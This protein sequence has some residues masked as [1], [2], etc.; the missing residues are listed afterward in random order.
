MKY[1]KY[2]KQILVGNSNIWLLSN[3]TE[4]VLIDTGYKDNFD[5][6]EMALKRNKIEYKDVK[7]IIIT[8]SHYDHCGH[9]QELKKL[10]NAKIVAHNLAKEEIE[11]GFCD[12][13]AGTKLSTKFVSWFGKRLNTKFR[14]FKASNVDI[15]FDDNLKLNAG[16]LE[17]ELFY[18][19]GH[20]NNSI[21][22]AVENN[23]FTGDTCF[24]VMKP[25]VYPPFA[26]DL[27]LL[28]ESWKELIERDAEL[29]FPGHGKAFE[30]DKLKMSFRQYFE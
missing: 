26:D 13:P 9:L 18:T 7:Y 20:N 11:A 5:K 6:I 2:I 23:I 24:N 14:T 19:P 22:I 17:L 15:G 28:K 30:V 25:T 1:P 12:I 3:K 16:D 4:S 8:H 29:Y 21:C 27:T 10:T